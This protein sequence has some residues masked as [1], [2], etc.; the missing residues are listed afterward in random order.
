MLL[1]PQRTD[2]GDE[3][4][5]HV[6]RQPDDPVLRHDQLTRPAV[7]VGVRPTR[8]SSTGEVVLAGDAAH[9]V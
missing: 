3:F 9:G 4:S 7:S 8:S 6:R 1:V 2:F 5:D